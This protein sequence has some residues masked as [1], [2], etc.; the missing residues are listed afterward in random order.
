MMISFFFFYI[1]FNESREQTCMINNPTA[2]DKNKGK[3]K[4]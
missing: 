4:F 3:M 1:V 2:R